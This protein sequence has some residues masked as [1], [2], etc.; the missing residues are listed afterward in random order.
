[1]V[2]R[3]FVVKGVTHKRFDILNLLFGQ[4]IQPSSKGG[5]FKQKPNTNFDD[6]SS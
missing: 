5:K 1:M 3:N 2:T 4:Q 6:L